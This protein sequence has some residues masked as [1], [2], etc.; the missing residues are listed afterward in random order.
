MPHRDI[1]SL[2]EVVVCPNMRVFGLLEAAAHELSGDI[3]YGA[4][5][6]VR[7][8]T[9]MRNE[10][11]RAILNVGAVGITVTRL[12]LQKLCEN[13]PGLN[14]AGECPNQERATAIITAATQN[15]AERPITIQSA[16]TP[17]GPP[18]SRFSWW[19]KRITITTDDG[20]AS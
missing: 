14:E 3:S 10:N 12:A 17:A 1:E 4:E 19:P 9:L 16:S 13:C 6:D 2:P 5:E 15:F 8:S 20:K 18:S 7:G 11:A